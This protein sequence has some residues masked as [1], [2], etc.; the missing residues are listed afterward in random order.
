MAN[1]VCASGV[2][3]VQDGCSTLCF[4]PGAC[5]VRDGWS[6]LRCSPRACIVQMSGQLCIAINELFCTHMWPTGLGL[7]RLVLYMVGG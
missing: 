6:T 5:I 4:D 2:C 3:I 1:L 7:Q